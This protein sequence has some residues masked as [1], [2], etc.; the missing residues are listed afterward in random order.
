MYI[1]ILQN[2]Y[3]SDRYWFIKNLVGEIDKYIILQTNSASWVN[4]G[5]VIYVSRTK[6]DP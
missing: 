6:R 1:C 3:Q 5:V 2:I 4:L